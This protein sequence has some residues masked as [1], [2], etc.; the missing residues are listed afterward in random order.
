MWP[1]KMF[2]TRVFHPNSVNFQNILNFV[3]I[4]PWF[5]VKLL[6]YHTPKSDGF[7]ILTFWWIAVAHIIINIFLKFWKVFLSKYLDISWV[8]THFQVFH[9]NYVHQSKR[10]VCQKYAKSKSLRKLSDQSMSCYCD[11]PFLKHCNYIYK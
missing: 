4:S 1:K 5:R 10:L 6:A 7:N 8:I 9:I 11:W 2:C 3:R